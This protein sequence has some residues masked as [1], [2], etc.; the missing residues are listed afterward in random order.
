VNSWRRLLDNPGQIFDSPHSGGYTN[1]TTATRMYIAVPIIAKD[2]R[3]R[4]HHRPNLHQRRPWRRIG[5]RRGRIG[6]NGRRAR[7][8]VLTWCATGRDGCAARY[9][10]TQSLKLA[11]SVCHRVSALR[12]QFGQASP[13]SLARVEPGFQIRDLDFCGKC[14]G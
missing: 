3:A 1:K 13:I 10:L 5:R 11:R 4:L 14:P 12:Q 2:D 9:L 6:Y 8:G 7:I